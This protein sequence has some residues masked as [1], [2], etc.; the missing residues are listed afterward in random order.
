MRI[1]SLELENTKSYHNGRISFTDGV[2]AIVGHNGAGK[3]TILEAI[4]FA[5]FDSLNGYKHS[6]FVREGAKSATVNVTFISNVDERH[7]QVTRRCGSSNQYTVFD[8]ELGVKLCEG[9]ADVTDFL[10]RHMGIDPTADLARLFSDAVGVPQGTFTAAFLQT[11]SQ[12]KAIFDPL[13]QVEEYKEAFDKLLPAVSAVKDRRQKLEVEK[14]ALAARLEALPGLE[15]SIAQRAQA[16]ADAKVQVATVSQQLQHV[17]TERAALEAIQKQVLEVQKQQQQASQQLAIVTAQYKSAEQSY[18][19]ATQ[20]QKI[21]QANTAGHAQYVQRQ[22]Q[23]QQLETQQRA[24]QQQERQL[25][26]LEKQLSAKEA[27]SQT[28]TRELSAVNRAE[29]LVQELAAAVREQTEGEA[30]LTVAQ[31]QSARLNDARTQ[32]ARQQADCQRLQERAA[33]LQV[34]L[35]EA[36]HLETTRVNLESTLEKLRRVIDTNKEALARYKVEA[37]AAKEQSTVL[38]QVAVAQCPVCEQPL[39]EAHRQQLLHRNEERLSTL[40]NQYKTEQQQ[41][42]LDEQTLQTQQNEIKQLEQTLRTLP[43]AGEEQRVQ[44]ELSAAQMAFSESQK[45]VAELAAAPIQVQ[46]LQA[47]LAALGD[48]RQQT[49]IAAATI[50]RRPALMQQQTQLTEA[51]AQLRGQLTTIQTALAAYQHLDEELGQVAA[52]L[53]EHLHAY[54]AVL[55][56]QQLADTYA[57]RAADLARLQELQATATQ[58]VARQTAAFHAVQAQFDQKE[59]ATLLAREQ[60]LLSQQGGLQTQ[61]TMLQKEQSRAQTELVELQAQASKLA[62]VCQ[63][64]TELA[65]QG[66]TLDTLRSLLRQ[67]GP[68]IT[69][70]LIKQISDGAAQIFSELMQDYTRHL[71]WAED[72]GIT[73]EVDGRERQFAQLS[74]GEQMSAALSVR[75]ALLREMSNIDVAFFDEPTTNLDETRRDSLARQ[76]L[77]VKGFRQLFVISHDD[78][79]EQVTQNLIR[80]ARVDGASIVVQS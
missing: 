49:A 45:R 72:Y 17:A 9:K 39:T 66:A 69:K 36:G 38:Q 18:A 80:I 33:A 68:Y 47:R 10:R 14:A 54:Q 60:M 37:D 71:R 19:E 74:G 56:H 8:P 32:L 62:V 51:I 5:L 57:M 30:A 12:R 77:D 21:V 1:V 73:L 40:R 67:A 46:E 52:A 50:A 35:A 34:Q 6:D 42:K 76:I 79:F 75:L 43:R 64:E 27:E 41:I 70:A 53:K 13:L 25:A 2:N 58:E 3:S 26:T 59:Y 16:L 7:Y 65:E 55:G 48:P 29:A 31:Q 24:R 78:T 22:A 15:A 44:Q 28:L 23:Q 63:Q 61:I 20:A 11:P 4:G